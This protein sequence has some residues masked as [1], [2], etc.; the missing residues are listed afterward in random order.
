M[1]LAIWESKRTEDRHSFSFTH[2]AEPG[3]ADFVA[4]F[5]PGL[6]CNQAE[7]N[8]PGWQL[9]AFQTALT[10]KG[11]PKASEDTALEY[12]VNENQEVIK[13]SSAVDEVTVRWSLRRAHPETIWVLAQDPVT[14][15]PWGNPFFL[16][17]S[18]LI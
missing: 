8:N 10:I 17:T 13:Q 11:V 1:H 3:R 7:K 12:E 2:G 16:E 9:G 15:W 18:L 6:D 4:V 5:H 14:A